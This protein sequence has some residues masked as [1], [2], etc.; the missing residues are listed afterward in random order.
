MADFDAEAWV[1]GFETWGGAVFVIGEDV[2][3]GRATCACRRLDELLSEIEGHPERSAAV[4][5]YVRTH[6]RRRDVYMARTTD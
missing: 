3:I 6:A 5:E 2:M 1:H 4:R